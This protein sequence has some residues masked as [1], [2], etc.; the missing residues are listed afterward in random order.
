MTC[1]L[2]N[3]TLLHQVIV[4]DNETRLSVRLFSNI[5]QGRGRVA[6]LDIVNIPHALI[7]TFTHMSLIGLL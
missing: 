3:M 1:H 5:A 4:G 7:S 2:H 6:P